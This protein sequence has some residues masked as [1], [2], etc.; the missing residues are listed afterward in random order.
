MMIPAI[1]CV[2]RSLFSN[3]PQTAAFPSMAESFGTEFTVV[4]VT[5]DD[6]GPR[7]RTQLWV[8]A[9]KPE[10]ALTLVLSEVPE[11]WTGKLATAHLTSK[12]LKA[13]K[14]LRLGPGEVYELTK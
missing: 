6:P 10:Q 1:L 12:Q 3:E 11:G 8:A 7:P 5:A 4:E 9:A 2:G 13:M 14:D